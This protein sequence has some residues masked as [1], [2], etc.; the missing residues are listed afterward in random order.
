[1]TTFHYGHSLPLSADE[2]IA[3]GALEAAAYAIYHATSIW[4]GEVKERIDIEVGVIEVRPGQN[5]YSHFED[6][7]MV[8]IAGRMFSWRTKNYTEIQQGDRLGIRGTVK[9]HEKHMGVRQT[10]IT[11]C[12]FT[13]FNV[14]TADEA[15]QLEDL[16]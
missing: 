10:I 16:S 5:F 9:A 15:A 2:R 1:M 14:M 8:D 3:I 11:R 4:Y 7:T 12:N 6:I 13:K